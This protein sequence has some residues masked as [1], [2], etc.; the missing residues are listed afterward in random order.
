VVDA[1]GLSALV[2]VFLVAICFL[3]ESPIA[4]QKASSIA[5]GSDP[6]LDWERPSPVLDARRVIGSIPYQSPE[7]IFEVL[8]QR[9]YECTMLEGRGNCA[10]K[11]RGLS[12]FL[13]KAGIPFH[14]VD[15]L[16]IDGFLYGMGHTLARV[17][18]E[19]DG[20]TRVGLIDVLEGAL[21]VEGSKP[22]DLGELRRAKPFT[23]ELLP[24]N[25]RCDGASEYYGTFLEGSVI[26]TTDPNETRRY[27]RFIESI[28]F[29]VGELRFQRL[30]FNAIAVVC[31]QFPFTRVSQADYERLFKGRMIVVYAASALRWSAR[32]LVV[33]F[34]ASIVLRVAEWIRS[35]TSRSRE[36]RSAGTGR[37]G[38][39]AVTMPA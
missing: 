38:R 14:R 31:G 34:A 16:P 15:M 17:K 20:Q 9:I 2:I 12:V 7:A 5:V 19:L 24:I 39:S 4:F 1:G 6:A 27:F 13:V 30:C 25:K 8:P 10:N 22:M 21:L 3:I 18:Y 26:G 37:S 29:P 11:V 36:E 33:L 23:I 28:Y 35:R 32:L